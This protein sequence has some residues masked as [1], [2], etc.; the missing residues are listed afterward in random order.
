M[1]INIPNHLPA[2]QVLE[3]EHIFVMDESRAFHQDIRPQKIVILN[4]MPKKIQTET[5]LLRMLGNSPLQVHFTF[6]IPSTHTPKNTARQ[7]L[8]EFYTDFSS[9]RH[10]R[11]DGMII[12]GAPIE[13]LPFEDVSYWEE[14]KEIMEWSKTNVTSTLHICW[15]A[16]AGLY[17]HYGIEKV[18]L[19]KKIFGVFE[20]TVLKKHERLV[21]GF[22]ELYYVPHSR[23]TDI[24]TE[25]L[26]SASDLDVLSVSEEAGVCLI[27]SKDEKQIFLTGHP[28]YDTDTLL[29]EYERDIER[30][31]S[32]VEAPKYYFAPGGKEPVN[33]W[34]AHATLLF[35]NW[36]NY[37]VYQETPYEWD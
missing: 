31:L 28:E 11:F 7:H 26:Q 21:R 9:I 3:S 8:D 1:P 25:Q 24:N 15:G 2:K 18:E 10:K 4:L 30:K 16:Q 13:H 33:R 36:L 23:H 6:L 32:N 19:P 20:H 12:T 37:Y 14:L 34:K 27:V 5:Q 22:D 17:Y 35:M 29:Q